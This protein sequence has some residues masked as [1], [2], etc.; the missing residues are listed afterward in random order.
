MKYYRRA[1]AGLDPRASWR[2]QAACAQTDPNLFFPERGS[3]A[4]EAKAVCMAC[5]VRTECLDHALDHE[6]DGVWGGLSAD[7]RN[8][9]KRTGHV[10]TATGASRAEA[11]EQARRQAAAL[12]EEGLSDVQVAAATGLGRTTVGRIRRD[13][14]IP[15]QYHAKTAEQTYAEQT[16]PVDGGHVRWKGVSQSA[17]L[18]GRVWTAGRLAFRVGHGRDPEGKVQ[19]ACNRPSCV[20]PEHLTDRLMREQARRAVTA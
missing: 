9:L 12:L 11:Y 13:L 2:G 10:P 8:T 18:G 3:S 17:T 14:G 1:P 19:V 4:Q 16:E 6:H 20:H 15:N 5:P 7:E